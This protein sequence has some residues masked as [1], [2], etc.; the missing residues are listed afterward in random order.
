MPD[1]SHVRA[2]RLLL[3]I[4]AQTYDTQHVDAAKFCDILREIED[5]PGWAH[6]RVG[7][8]QRDDNGEPAP[9]RLANL[10]ALGHVIEHL[11]H[12][13][14]A[15]MIG[16]AVD[17]IPIPG[18]DE[19]TPENAQNQNPFLAGL[20]P[21]M[22]RGIIARLEKLLIDELD[23]V[24]DRPAEGDTC[25]VCGK[26]FAADDE[27]GLGDTGWAHYSCDDGN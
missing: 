24:H 9:Q 15:A 20:D 27:A 13:G 3:A 7:I 26:G 1:Q 23:G 10:T 11:V 5:T 17:P 2:L 6:A 8:V 18:D 21:P 14:L 16:P 22:V 25:V 19:V 4:A 12:F